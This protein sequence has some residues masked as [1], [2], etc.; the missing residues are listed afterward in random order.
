VITIG[1]L[2]PPPDVVVAGLRPTD[3]AMLI[4]PGSR[5]WLDGGCSVCEEGHELLDAGR[6]RNLRAQP[7]RWPM[8]AG[9]GPVAHQQLGGVRR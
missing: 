6:R 9:R 1:G 5:T 8:K 2:R 7:W 3:S 4:L